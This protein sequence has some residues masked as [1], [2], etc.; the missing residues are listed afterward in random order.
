MKKIDSETNSTGEYFFR[1]DQR[2][3]QDQGIAV[4]TMGIMNVAQSA[5]RHFERLDLAE[6]RYQRAGMLPDLAA[7]AY[8]KKIILILLYDIVDT[9]YIVLNILDF[10]ELEL[11][12]SADGLG[13][14]GE[15]AADVLQIIGTLNKQCQRVLKIEKKY[16]FKV[17]FSEVVDE[18]EGITYTKNIHWQDFVHGSIAESF[19]TYF[20]RAQ[21]SLK[22]RMQHSPRLWEDQTIEQYLK[23]KGYDA[24]SAMVQR[25]ERVV[26]AV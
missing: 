19:Y 24:L 7:Q 21:D 2:L 3:G 25:L 17:D 11:E 15:S 5:E 14:T 12:A 1:L 8:E 13:L 9:S 22:E 10:D 6:K 20:S 23:R 26:F 4:K 16:D 18:L